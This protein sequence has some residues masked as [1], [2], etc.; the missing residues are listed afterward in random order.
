[1]TI[2]SDTSSISSLFQI[3]LIQ[4]LHSLFGEIII[5][6]A[7]KEELCRMKKQELA[8]AKLDWIT[9]TPP[10]DKK[11]VAALMEQLDLGESES[12]ALAIETQAEY[13][14]IDEFHGRQVAENLGI[15]IVGVLG[16]LIQAKK[17]N[18]IIDLEAE[19][20]KL[21]VIG[22]RLDRKLVKS[23]LDRI[24]KERL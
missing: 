14:L 4:I 21:Y 16:V 13:L 1:M 24:N 22:F 5:T 17:K 6:P 20:E 7:V 18:L 3:G 10:H 2:V 19:I 12:I 15:R 11:M 23:V 8:L 9:V